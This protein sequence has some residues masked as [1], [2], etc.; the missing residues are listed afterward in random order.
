MKTAWDA[1]CNFFDSAEAYAKGQSEVEM[2]KAIRDLG[3]ERQKV[4]VATKVGLESR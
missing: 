1:G 2:G 3:V 4:V